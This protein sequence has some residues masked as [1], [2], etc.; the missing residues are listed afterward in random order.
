MMLL[1]Q[2]VD[3]WLRHRFGEF[4]HQQFLLVCL[5][6]LITFCGGTTG[7]DVKATKLPP[8]TARI[9]KK[10]IQLDSP[11]DKLQLKGMTSYQHA[12]EFLFQSVHLCCFYLLQIWLHCLKTTA[13]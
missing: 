8:P 11:E 4:V 10:S 7:L 2:F 6:A 5:V 3:P 1:K 12:L 13:P 9:L